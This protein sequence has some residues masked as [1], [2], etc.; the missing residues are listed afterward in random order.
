MHKTNHHLATMTCTWQTHFYES[1]RLRTSSIISSISSNLSPMPIEGS[2][3]SSLS[4]T[5]ETG[6]GSSSAFR[7]FTSATG[8]SSSPST[9]SA[10]AASGCSNGRP[11]QRF[12]ELP[13]H[14]HPSGLMRPLTLFDNGRNSGFK[15]ACKQVE[16]YGQFLRPGR[17][18]V[19]KLFEAWPS[20]R[21]LQGGRLDP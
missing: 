11:G 1:S 13:N 9:D 2:K 21:Q 17:F 20:F 12:F 10:K 19:K 6:S 16:G 15:P 8:L 7:S 18:I 14:G 4:S 5:V 3:C